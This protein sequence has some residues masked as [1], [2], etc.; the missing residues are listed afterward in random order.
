MFGEMQYSE[1]D[2][3]RVVMASDAV[4]AIR[5][6]ASVISL[7]QQPCLVVN[8]I[9]KYGLLSPI[10]YGRISSFVPTSGLKCRMC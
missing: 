4:V 7:E 1:K 6:D 10:P 3:G 2:S 9:V 5:R 8:R